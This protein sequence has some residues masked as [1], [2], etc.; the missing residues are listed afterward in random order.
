MFC[1]TC[2]NFGNRHDRQLFDTLVERV[3]FL[4]Y[5]D[6]KIMHEKKNS[7]KQTP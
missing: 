4:I 3:T 2:Y 7:S 6:A 1:H 5:N